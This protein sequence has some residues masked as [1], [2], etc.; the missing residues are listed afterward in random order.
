MKRIVV[1]VGA[2]LLCSLVWISPASAQTYYPYF[3]QDSVRVDESIG[4]VVVTVRMKGPG[5]VE[6]RTE[7]GSCTRRAMSPTTTCGAPYARAPGDYGA[8]S[9]EVVFNEADGGSRQI[10]V[11][12]VDDRQDEGLEKF[13][14][15]ATDGAQRGAVEVSIVDDDGDSDDADDPGSAAMSS[16]TIRLPAPGSGPIAAPP[17]VGAPPTTSLSSDLEMEIAAGELKPGPGFELTSDNGARRAPDRQDEDG[18]S[19]TSLALGL[20]AAAAA[21]GGVAMAARRRRQWSP[22]RS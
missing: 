8:V 17:G 22:T 15:V 21:T 12:I 9:G 5:R 1:V 19:A 20:G 6:Y 10:T 7:D 3:T 11:P 4:T 16:T 18:G 14:V 2:V 13:M